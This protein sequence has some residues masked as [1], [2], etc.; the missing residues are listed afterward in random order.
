MIA[1]V[2][3]YPNISNTIKKIFRKALNILE[4]VRCFE[5][6]RLYSSY[7]KQLTK[8]IFCSFLLL[9]NRNDLFEHGGIIE[10][11]K[12]IK[13][14][15]TNSSYYNIRG[16][17]KFGLRNYVGAIEDYS[18]AIKYDSSF[19]LAYENRIF[20]KIKIDDHKGIIS[21]C[22]QLIKLDPNNAD[23]WYQRAS[24]KRSLLDLK[25]AEEDYY[26]A[27]TIQ[28]S[29]KISDELSLYD[30]NKR[31]LQK[32]MLGD[33]V[34]AIKDYDQAIELS[35]DTIDVDP[36]K[37]FGRTIACRDAYSSR[38]N[39]KTMIKDYHGAI[40]D[41]NNAI[42][43]GNNEK[44]DH[45]YFNRGL[46]KANL[47]DIR[48]AILDFDE[49]IRLTPDFA[50]AYFTRG[51]VKLQSGERDSACLDWSKAGELGFSKAYDMI[52]EYCN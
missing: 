23:Y 48:G 9:L 41:Y 18:K 29:D 28:E 21:D 17:A 40:S 30:Y 50:N 5:V 15:S 52:K 6:N 51:Y 1:I 46:A 16:T 20:A 36:I 38:G 3:N 13:I 14:D 27:K 35:L 4:T 26:I 45:N 34:G 33:Y 8:F 2:N 32:Y 43:F 11:D 37:K 10:F 49:A 24:A 19:I 42:K 7:M 44:T 12:A 25:G 47:G 22:N 31:G 39:A